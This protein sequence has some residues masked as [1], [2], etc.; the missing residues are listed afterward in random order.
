[1]ASSQSMAW[2]EALELRILELET[3]VEGWQQLGTVGDDSGFRV[4]PIVF[5]L[6]WH[7]ERLRQAFE[8]PQQ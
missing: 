5:T 2:R 6:G 8:G 3:L 7:V 4:P 1:M